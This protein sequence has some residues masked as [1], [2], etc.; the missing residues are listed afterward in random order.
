MLG[1][2]REL[3]LFAFPLLPEA[4][5]KDWWQD[6]FDFERLHLSAVE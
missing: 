1:P 4:R 6:R 5:R 2:N 3:L